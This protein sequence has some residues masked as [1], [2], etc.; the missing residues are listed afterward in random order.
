MRRV[1]LLPATQLRVNVSY[2]ASLG[3]TRG[4]EILMLMMRRVLFSPHSDIPAHKPEV[5]FHTRDSSE[6]DT[7][8]ER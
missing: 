3:Y 6:K 8:G 1:D 7:G 5:G 2:A 4:F